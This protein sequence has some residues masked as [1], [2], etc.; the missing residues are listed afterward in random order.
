MEPG[1][2]QYY[3]SMRNGVT[4]AD[5]DTSWDRS[6]VVRNGRS[7]PRP[8]YTPI[9]WDDTASAYRGRIGE[10]LVFRCPPG[11]EAMSIWG[12][13]RYTDD[14]SICTAGVHAGRITFKNGGTVAIIMRPG[15]S[16][17]TGTVRNGVTSSDWNDWPGSFSFVG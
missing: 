16:E 8:N 2:S 4:S 3:G 6:F 13:D 10:R 7:R 1:A 5:W 12:T 9:S 14:S 11:G 15:A 17:F